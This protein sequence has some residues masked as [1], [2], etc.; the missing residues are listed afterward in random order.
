[1]E[2]RKAEINDLKCIMNIYKKAREFMA[3][4][5]NET[6]W[7]ANYPTTDI[8]E[9]DIANGN[10]Y[11]CS[12]NDKI[13]ATFAF[14]IGIEPTYQKISG[15]FHSEKTYGTI[16]RL[17]SS[18][19]VKG[20]SKYCFDFCSEKCN[21]L[22]IDTHKDNKFMLAAIRKYNFQE[23]GIIQVLDGS[24]RIAFDYQK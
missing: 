11:V 4:N 15:H 23:C 14:I 21:Y 24:E 9:K 18:G 8:I 16:H 20:I 6:Q 2:I 3:C 19:E 17:A 7:K 22:R 1:M 5:G 13:V 12:K 10:C